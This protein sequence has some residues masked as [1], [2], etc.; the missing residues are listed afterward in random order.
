MPLNH[1]PQAIPDPEH[2]IH[3]LDNGLIVGV[4]PM[5]WLHEV[6]ATLMVRAGSRFEEPQQAGIAHFL[7]HMLFKGTR[8]IS[9][10]TRFHAHLESMA[11]DMN[12]A[13]G[14]ETNAYW[15]TLPPEWLAEG[16]TAFCDMFTQPAL[17]DI[18]TERRVILEEMRED[19]NDQGELAVP[20]VL[21]GMALWPGHPLARS[22]LGSR[23]TVGRIQVPALR[24]YL[25]RHYQGGNMAL[26]F[27]GPIDTRAALELAD[28]TLGRLP[29]GSGGNVPRPPDNQPT[30]PHWVA[31]DDQSSQFTLSLFFR[32]GGFRDEGYHPIA[33]LRRLLDD[34]FSSRLQAVVR[35]YR[36]LAYDVWSAFT[37]HSDAGFLE[38]GATL[39][40]DHLDEGFQVLWEQLDSLVLAPPGAEE[41]QRLL[42][43]W[44]ASLLVTLDRPAELIERYVGDRLFEA[45]ETL[46]HSWQQAAALDPAQLPAF[47]ARLLHPE[48][49]AVVLVGPEARKTLP[50]LKN[51]F[52]RFPGRRSAHGHL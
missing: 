3:R 40:P 35:E 42:V 28:R 5:P 49:L 11:A 38:V 8:E 6:G 19:E 44:R 37:T 1:P 48:N 47:A 20:S 27:C 24:E 43:R 17:A 26:T 51:A 39:S 46:E 4:F 33:A 21:G 22:V 14:Q 41:W 25:K 15:I 16:F 36:G 7:E 9:D 10:P 31:V 29:G 13:T 12:A 52:A 30:G 23:E 34:G 50:R 18:E 32:T 2:T 45:A